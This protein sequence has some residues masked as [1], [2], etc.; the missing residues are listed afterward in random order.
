VI[1]SQGGFAGGWILYVKGGQLTYCYNFA[2]L[3]KYVIQQRNH[4]HLANIK[5]ECTSRTTGAGLE[6]AGPSRST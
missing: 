3:E 1:L 5:Y 4:L 6:R 2:G